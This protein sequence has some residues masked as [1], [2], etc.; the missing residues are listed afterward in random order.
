[1]VADEVRSLASKTQQSTEDIQKMIEA[2]QSGVTQAVDAINKGS[3][4]AEGTVDLA[5][6]TLEALNQILESTSKVSEVSVSTAT[7]TEEQSHVTEDIDRN[8]TELAD[9][10][11]IN[12]ENSSD[13]LAAAQLAIE[14]AEQ[15]NQQL[16]RFKVSV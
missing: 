13:S 12:L 5:G 16:S 15:L 1:M 6:Q 4:V 7:S 9:K 11:R 3:S 14:K 8:L 2:L 10:T